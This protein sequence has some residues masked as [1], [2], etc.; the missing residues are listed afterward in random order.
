MSQQR[1]GKKAGEGT[2]RAINTR[3]DPLED[4]G[5]TTLLTG[6]KNHGPSLTAVEDA[7][8]G[9]GVSRLTDRARRQNLQRQLEAFVA[10]EDVPDDVKAGVK[11]YFEN[12]HQSGQTDE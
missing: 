11:A 2:D 9:T 10:R 6:Q 1:G 4:N 8:S 3:T 7:D 12:I 5:N